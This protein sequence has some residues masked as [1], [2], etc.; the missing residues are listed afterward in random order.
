MGLSVSRNL[1]PKYK[2]QAVARDITRLLQLSP[3]LEWW[4]VRDYYEP[5]LFGGR[6]IQG[7][8]YDDPTR[9]SIAKA[10]DREMRYLHVR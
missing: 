7:S 4:Q 10:I 5:E 1:V 3:A 8:S 9:R 6:S 2:Y